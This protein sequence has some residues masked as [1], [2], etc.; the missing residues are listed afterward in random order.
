PADLEEAEVVLAVGAPARQALDLFLG[1]QGWRRFGA[2]A[3]PAGLA[4][5]AG[6]AHGGADAASL[7]ELVHRDNTDQ[8]RQQYLAALTA[9]R[10]QLR[11][12]AAAQSA[13][14]LSERERHLAGLRLAEALLEQYPVRFLRQA[15]GL[16]LVVLFALACLTLTIGFVRLLRRRD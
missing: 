16:A 3:A 15:A 12:D 1:T 9:A 10:E 14:L 2:P 11:K 7:L 4:Q 8:G 13:E 5:G 6:K